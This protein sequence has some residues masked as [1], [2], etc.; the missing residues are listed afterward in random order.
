MALLVLLGACSNDGKDG[1]N[2]RVDAGAG[3]VDASTID[4]PRATPTLII[5]G[6]ATEQ[7][8]SGAIAVDG[9]LIEAYRAGDETTP[10]AMTTTNA[11]GNYT[12]TIETGTVAIDG[13]LKATKAGL[14]DTYLYPPEPVYQDFDMASIVMA[15]QANFD[16]MSTVAQ[17][18]QI[19]ENGFIGLVV[20]NGSSPVQGATISSEPTAGAPGP[21]V[22]RYNGTVGTTL[23][24][25]ATPT[26]TN[27]DG[28]AYVFNAPPGQV[29]VSA[30]K[31]GMTF[32]SHAVKVRP[33]V[34]TTT[35]IVP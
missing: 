13:Y 29:T 22:Y 31:T 8:F 10:I 26:S 30:M 27:T 7:T 35:L 16:S 18:G 4:S 19:P 15:T 11:G 21:T 34:I 20:T 5:S 24:P 9:A 14:L 2:P 33:G 25:S 28:V 6:R 32:K 23:F 3:G 12:L 1:V 17:G